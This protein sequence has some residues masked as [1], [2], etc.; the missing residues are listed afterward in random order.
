MVE[1][2]ELQIT[3]KMLIWHCD[4]VHKKSMNECSCY[5][6]FYSRI[7]VAKYFWESFH[8]YLKW[9]LLLFIIDADQF[10]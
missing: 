9:R 8:S 3:I 7:S 2:V 1:S 6:I 5:C 4:F 10:T